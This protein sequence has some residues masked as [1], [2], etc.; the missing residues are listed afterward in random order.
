MALVAH[1]DAN[2]SGSTFVLFFKAFDVSTA[3]HAQFHR[4]ARV[5]DVYPLVAMR[6]A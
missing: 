3:A 6:F 2:E 4:K 1:A 5:F